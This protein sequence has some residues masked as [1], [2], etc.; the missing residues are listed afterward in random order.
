LTIS[1]NFSET[2]NRTASRR[3]DLRLI[4]PWLCHVAGDQWVASGLCRKFGFMKISDVFCPICEAAYEMAEAVSIQGN[5][6][7][8]HCALCGNLLASWDGSR[9]TAFRLTMP[10]ER[11]YAGVPVPPAPERV[12]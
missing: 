12:M 10:V 8:V 6:G 7:Q 1:R 2:V 11:R 5:P 3:H 9:L 4:R